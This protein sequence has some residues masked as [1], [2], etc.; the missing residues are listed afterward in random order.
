MKHVYEKYINVDG[1][2]V[3]KKVECELEFE[4]ETHSYTVNGASV[5]SVSDI[6]APL[7]IDLRKVDPY[8]LQLAASRG[9]AVH[10][11]T[12]EFDTNGSVECDEPELYGYLAAY[13]SFLRDYNIK[14]WDYIE[15]QM[16]NGEFA[17]TADRIGMIDYV[18][19]VVDIKT[20]S[21]VDMLRTAVQ[22]EAYAK[23]YGAEPD[24]I[25]FSTAVLHLKKNGTY[26]YH[27]FTD[28][29]RSKA[30][31]ILSTLVELDKEIKAWKN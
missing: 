15:H 22:T 14:E 31:S 21:K 7:T 29:E 5:P 12:E 19:T 17:G 2:Y 18:P 25:V 30:K 16:T 6:I 28:E 13:I 3:A 4:A 24:H 9:T 10:E 27:T 20:S 11:L 26:S 8:V 1:D 23:L